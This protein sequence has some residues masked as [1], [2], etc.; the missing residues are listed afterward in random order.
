MRKSDQSMLGIGII[1]AGSYGES[2]AQA[3][4]E[5]TNAKLV[6]A[7]RTN[8]SALD[9][10][11]QKFGGRGYADYRDLLADDSVAAVVIATPHHLHTEIAIAA[12]HAGK[13]ILLEKPMAPS[14]AEC[15]AIIAA[16]CQAG[17]KLMVGH[18]NRFARPYLVAKELIESG[19][20]GQ[21]VQGTATMQKFW[22]E[23]NRR[24]WHL[25]REHGGGVWMTVGIHPLDRLTWL[26]DSAV[27]TV[28]AQFGTYFHSMAADDTGMVFLRYENGAAGNVISTGYSVGAPK[29]TTE[30][31]CTIGT[32]I[33][34]YASGVQIGRNDQWRVIPESGPSGSWMQEALAN[35]WR[36][37]VKAI[38]S[39]SEPPVS[40]AVAREIMKVVFA[41]EASSAQGRE[42][43]IGEFS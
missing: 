25:D 14:L 8:V 3:L 41:A 9:A 12:A 10:F 34:D 39:D 36:A 21:V 23:P 35:E 16:A 32:L 33:V 6:A 18:V 27:T 11:V 17:V 4:A 22:F 37:F 1:G 19:E 24:E 2:H 15:D 40:G 7:S 42:I 20:M 26:I 13:H 43:R 5:V 29:H 31:T 38:Q 28:S 30:L